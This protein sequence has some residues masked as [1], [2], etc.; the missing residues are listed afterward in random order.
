ML[1]ILPQNFIFSKIF[2]S[3]FLYTE[4]WFTDQNSKLLV[5]KKRKTTLV[6]NLRVTYKNYSLFS[7]TERLK[8]SFKK[9]NS[10]NNRS[11]WRFDW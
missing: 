5:I 3:G 4:I 2:N 7:S 8:K 6:I 9:S 11:N 10:K 1:E